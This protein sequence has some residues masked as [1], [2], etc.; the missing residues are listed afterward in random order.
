MYQVSGKNLYPETKF[1]FQAEDLKRTSQD[2]ALCSDLPNLQGY[3]SKF[4]IQPER[5]CPKL[6]IFM[7][8]IQV[9]LVF[10]IEA[11]SALYTKV[12][13]EKFR[14]YSAVNNVQL[15]SYCQLVIVLM[16]VALKSF[17][18]FIWL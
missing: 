17:A 8:D 14:I 6:V 12:V 10:I 18:E 3:R 1:N 16:G 5:S 11:S 13:L 15:Q 2:S 4:N 9:T 7:S